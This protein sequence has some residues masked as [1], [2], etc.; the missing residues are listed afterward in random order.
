MAGRSRQ[1]NIALVAVFAALIAA[2]AL[3]P[4][5]FSLAG[6]PFSVQFM[7]VLLAPLV[8]GPWQGLAAIA[9]YVAAGAA[10]L[11]IFSGGRAGIGVL[12]GPTGGFL[13]GY[14]VAAIPIGYIGS[15]AL[16]R[17]PI[18]AATGVGL[19]LAAIVGIAVVYAFGIAG[20]VFR[21]HMELGD[22]TL[23]ML[24][25]IPLDLVKAAVAAALAMVLF[26]VFP[27]LLASRA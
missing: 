6:V 18:K 9:L 16:K 4:P 1:V 21:A 15:L 5:I 27:R 3:L 14:V 2:L 22:A 17:R 20:M 25:F 13:I 7:A 11:P 23:A 10:G 24:G 19:A 8:L 26:R 12:S